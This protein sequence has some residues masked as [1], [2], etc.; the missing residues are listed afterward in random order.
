MT[1][2]PHFSPASPKLSL[3]EASLLGVASMLGAGVFV[4]FAPAANFAG[5]YLLLAILVA[6]LVASLNARSMHQLSA[7]TTDAGGAYAY[8]RKFVSP[9]VGFVAGLAFIFGK[10]GSVASVA[11]AASSYIYPLATIEVAIIAIALMTIINIFG[12]NRTALGAIALSIPTLTLLVLIVFFGFT[13]T[14]S[15]PTASTNFS[16]TGVLTAAAL[17]FF[18]FAGYARVATLGEEVKK[19]LLNVPRAII[20]SL[21]AVLALYLLIGFSLQRQLQGNLATSLAPILDYCQVVIPWLPTELIILIAAA[22]CLGSLLSLLAG[23]SRTSAAMA[24]DRELPAFIAIRG[25]RFGSPYIADL[26]IAGAATTLLL[27]GDIVW[28][29]G[30]SSFAVLLYYAIA[31]LAAIKAAINRP[32]QRLLGLMGLVGCVVVGIFVPF[33]SILA[34]LLVLGLA[35]LTRAGL[36]RLGHATKL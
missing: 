6:G 16:A 4:V 11:L 36:R 20:I 31:N 32:A 18:A 9:T 26:L 28:T 22:A 29:I 12:I 30:V 2:S 24:K 1:Q 25:R 15:Q 19:P 8:G 35:L 5:S 3:F 10:V 14:A 23:I 7:A 21:F 13:T 27:L 33:Q 34:S 17:I